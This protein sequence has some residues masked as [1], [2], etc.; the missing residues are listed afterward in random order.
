MFYY[1][2]YEALYRKYASQLPLLKA[3]N[4]FQYV[5]FR[6]AYAAITALALSLIFGP[7]VIRKLTEFKFGQEI[8]EEGPASHQAKRGTPTMGGVMIIG[9][10]FI[11]TLLWADLKS[12]GV[13]VALLGMVGCGAIGF[14][15]D[16]LK[17]AR[18]R[19][20][21]LTG[22]Q[23]IAGQVL[24][25]VAVSALLFAATDYKSTLYV[26]FFKYLQPDLTVL[27][28]SAFIILVLTATSNTVNLTDGLDGL[29]IS[30]TVVAASALTGFVYVTGHAKFADYLDIP[31]TP[32]V[33]EV[34]IFAGALVGASLGFLWFNAPQAEVFMGDVGSLGIGG[35]LGTMAILIK[36]E[37]VLPILGGVFVLEGLSVMIQVASFKLRG[38]RVFK[39]APLHHHFELL[40]WK[41]PKIVFRFLIVAILFALLSLSTLKLR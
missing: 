31:H 40:G 30:V 8:R 1:I 28:Y 41:E 25:G 38:K 13:W 20:L 27:G 26:P 10:V 32:G 5:T 11:S 2:F 36:Q 19:S 12:P 7:V 29:A 6:T 17:I 15:D 18:K 3:L 39:M 4:V 35:A 14:A 9:S 34:T 21:G 24:V 22:R 33:G 23:K 37:L 16:S